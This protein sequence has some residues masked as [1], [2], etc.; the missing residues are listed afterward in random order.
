[1][2]AIVSTGGKQVKVSVGDKIFVE[3][4][5]AEVDAEYV[6]DNV[7]LVEDDKAK[8]NIDIRDKILRILNFFIRF[9]SFIILLH[10]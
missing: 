1:M 2:Y 6:F 3:K 8:V 4:L 9:S 10:F 7:L 5:E